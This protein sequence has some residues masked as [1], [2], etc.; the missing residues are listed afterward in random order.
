MYTLLDSEVIA[1]FLSF[2]ND[3]AKLSQNPVT[4]A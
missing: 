1:R 3:L 2:L 4:L